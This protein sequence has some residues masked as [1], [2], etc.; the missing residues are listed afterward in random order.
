MRSPTHGVQLAPTIR[1]GVLLVLLV[2]DLFAQQ[3]TPGQEAPNP[4]AKPG[5]PKAADGPQVRDLGPPL[6]DNAA[7]LKRLD[8]VLPV[9]LDGKLKRVVVVGEVCRAKYPLEFF[10]VL[11][12]RDYESVV[13]VDM[14]PR[15]VHA[16]LLALGAQPG[17]PARLE[18]RFEPAYG[19]EITIDVV[20]KGKDGK[21]EQAR[22]Q[23]WIRDKST[24][25]SPEVNWV[26]GGSA[27]AVDETTGKRIYLADD[28]DFIAV[29][30]LP[31]ALLDLP[32]RSATAI[33]ARTFEP[34]LERMPPQGTAV[35]LVIKPKLTARK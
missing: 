8:P 30:N 29:S 10:A 1:A 33:E 6:V 17:Q 26:F 9:W 31:T 22:A 13:V 12:G 18:P 7:D 21:R 25:K 32:I 20:W 3:G 5:D 11:R 27:F 4:V 34:F 15:I 14:R 19:T 35:T 28:G 23:E 16:A 24:G 2:S